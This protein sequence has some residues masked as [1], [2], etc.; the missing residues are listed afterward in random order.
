VP[1][2][3]AEAGIDRIIHEEFFR[4]AQPSV[5]V[6]ATV[7]P[8]GSDGI[9]R[10]S[11]VS[12]LAPAIVV[13]AQGQGQ[14]EASAAVGMSWT[15]SATSSRG[16]P[17]TRRRREVADVRLDDGERV[18]P[19]VADHGDELRPRDRFERRRLVETD[20]DDAGAPRAG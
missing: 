4:R 10:L 5:L 11:I 12:E 7:E 17:R 3:Q 13:L 20:A 6:D 19:A 15:T 16:R 18:A 9:N 2:S 14:R 8:L 1:S